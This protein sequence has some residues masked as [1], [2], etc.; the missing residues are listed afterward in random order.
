[1]I[2]FARAI[3]SKRLHRSV[4]RRVAYT[5]RIVH[6]FVRCQL[7][8]KR[9]FLR[10]PYPH[11]ATQ[12]LEKHAQEKPTLLPGNLAGSGVLPFSVGCW[13]WWF[14]SGRMVAP[15]QRAAFVFYCGLCIVA[16]CFANFLCIL[17]CDAKSEFQGARRSR[18]IGAWQETLLF[19]S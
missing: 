12:V 13:Y 15:N 4:V 11:W 1:M 8:G 3:P 18:V 17:P 2:A 9:V 6:C 10:S 5:A 14:V 16:C 19:K 7:V